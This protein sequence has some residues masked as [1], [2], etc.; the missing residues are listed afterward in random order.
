VPW[1]AEVE[2]LPPKCFFKSCFLGMEPFVF[3]FQDTT[4]S[5]KD[6]GGFP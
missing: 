3:R 1:I 6:N 4:C 5:S 2:D